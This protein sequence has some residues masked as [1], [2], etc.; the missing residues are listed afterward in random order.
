MLRWRDSTSGVIVTKHA[1]DW[2]ELEVLARGSWL[3]EACAGTDFHKCRN[4]LNKRQL[5]VWYLNRKRLSE[6]IGIRKIEKDIK[7]SLRINSSLTDLCLFFNSCLHYTQIFLFL[8]LTFNW[9]LE[10]CEMWGKT[11]LLLVI[12]VRT[13]ADLGRDPSILMTTMWALHT[14]CIPGWLLSGTYFSQKNICPVD[15]LPTRQS[16]CPWRW[17]GQQR[18]PW[19]RTGAEDRGT[20]L[21]E[22]WRTPLPGTWAL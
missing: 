19:W 20:P 4:Q 16:W 11:R 18:T 7:T 2:W 10:V 12:D 14:V 15:D 1:G 21:L 9:L 3:G 17:W 22:H 6:T 8:I 5:I 13:P